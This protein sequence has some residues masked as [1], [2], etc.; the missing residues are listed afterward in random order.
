MGGRVTEHLREL[1]ST[2]GTSFPGGQAGALLLIPCPEGVSLPGQPR[3]T[4]S[5]TGGTSQSFL[6]LLSLPALGWPPARE[7]GGHSHGDGELAVRGWSLHGALAWAPAAGGCS[8]R[9][10]LRRR[11]SS[12]VCAE[13]VLFAR[14][15]GCCA[16]G[17]WGRPRRSS[18]PVSR[19]DHPTSAACD[20]GAPCQSLQR[21]AQYPPSHC[22]APPVL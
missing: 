4:A 21:F 10:V 7:G 15:R 16:G 20:V 13:V 11:A 8:G 1:P 22:S 19:T 9:R 12:P 3:A 17:G 18:P 5:T 2:P 14:N 6:L